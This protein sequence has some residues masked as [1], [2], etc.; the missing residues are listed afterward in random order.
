MIDGTE[1]ENAEDF[2][3]FWKDLGPTEEIDILE[4]WTVFFNLEIYET[5]GAI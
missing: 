4:M 1:I 3:R 2:R 5:L